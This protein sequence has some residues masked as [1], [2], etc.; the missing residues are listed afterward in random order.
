MAS[1]LSARESAAVPEVAASDALRAFLESTDPAFA[2]RLDV[3]ARRELPARARGPREPR[4]LPLRAATRAAPRADLGAASRAERRRARSLHP[5]PLRRHGAPLVNPVSTP[6]PR[7]FYDAMW[8]RYGALDALS[9]AAFHRRRLIRKLSTE[10]A[11]R[12]ENVVD[13]GCG[14]G[15]LLVEP[16]AHCPALG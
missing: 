13:V 15:Q 5:G 16:G 10:L 1:A 12:A 2:D 8:E 14:Q 6:D 4:S 11:P 7:A 9:P 3:S